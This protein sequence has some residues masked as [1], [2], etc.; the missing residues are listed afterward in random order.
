MV[1][2]ILGLAAGALILVVGKAML[3]P[4]HRNYWL[5]DWLDN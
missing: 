3:G 1:S 2:F 5:E 4:R